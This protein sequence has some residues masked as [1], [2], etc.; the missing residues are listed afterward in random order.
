MT[1]ATATKAVNVAVC[2]TG[3]DET[4]CMLSPAC[5]VAQIEQVWCDVV[6]F[7]ECEWA[8]CTVPITHMSATQNMHTALTNPPRFTNTFII[9]FRP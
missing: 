6:E 3:A 7:S 2:K 8:A 1:A 4:V 9:P 5:A